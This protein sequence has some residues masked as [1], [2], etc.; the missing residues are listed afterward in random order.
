[1]DLLAGHARTWRNWLAKP[2]K[3]RRA[4]AAA[5]QLERGAARAQGNEQSASLLS[6]R[7]G[8]LASLQSRND[9]CADA[10]ARYHELS[11]DL[12]AALASGSMKSPTSSRHGSHHRAC[13]MQIER[14]R[15]LTA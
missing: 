4:R 13:Q 9:H 1:M 8:L 6:R 3:L 15:L 7:R 5:L 10:L 11:G 12:R 14:C 2:T